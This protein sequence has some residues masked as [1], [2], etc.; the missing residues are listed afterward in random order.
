[1]IYEFENLRERLVHYLREKLNNHIF[2]LNPL[3]SE[4]STENFIK[5]KDDVFREMI[6]QNPDLLKLRK[7][8]GLDYNS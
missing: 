7:E 8:L 1:M 5:T 2:E 6:A 3:V 4:G